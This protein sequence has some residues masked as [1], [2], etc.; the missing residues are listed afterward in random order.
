MP[1]TQLSLDTHFA[2]AWFPLS[3]AVLLPVQLSSNSAGSFRFQVIASSWVD[4]NTPQ[5]S[6][7]W[8][9]SCGKCQEANVNTSGVSFCKHPCIQF[10]QQRDSFCSSSIIK[11][12]LIAYRLIARSHICSSYLF[13]PNN[14]LCFEYVMTGLFRVAGQIS[15]AFC[16]LTGFSLPY[17][18]SR[19]N[20]WSEPSSPRKSPLFG[21]ISEI[22]I[23]L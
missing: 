16:A 13:F 11:P 15:T 1:Q 19:Q 2:D 7:S 14:L 10:H 22:S 9:V 17:T 21:N 12:F 3:D 18:F 20:Q 5:L 23:F 6:K 4:D 8:A